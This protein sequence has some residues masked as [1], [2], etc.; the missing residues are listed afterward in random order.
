[1]EGGMPQK[2]INQLKAQ[3]VKSQYQL[4]LSRYGHLQIAEYLVEQGCEVDVDK[5]EIDCPNF[6][7]KVKYLDVY[8]KKYKDPKID[9]YL[10]SISC[11]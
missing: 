4:S 11:A 5:V 8:A 6:L 9:E 7:P 3:N 10:K 2:V 1:M